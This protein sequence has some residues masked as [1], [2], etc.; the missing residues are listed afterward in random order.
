MRR[1]CE[2]GTAH[3]VRKKPRAGFY[4]HY[5]TPTALRLASGVIPALSGQHRNARDNQVDGAILDHQMRR[6]V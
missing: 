6:S 4:M 5:I 1:L 2:P 3:L